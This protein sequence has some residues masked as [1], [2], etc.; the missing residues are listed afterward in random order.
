MVVQ[1]SEA[2]AAG[3]IPVVI[4]DGLDLP[5]SQ[6]IQWEHASVRISESALGRMQCDVGHKGSTKHAWVTELL[7]ATTIL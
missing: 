2:I 6:L 4:A 5:L 7:T 1:V 3:A